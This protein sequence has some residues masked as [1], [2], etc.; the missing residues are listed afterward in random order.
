V[1][2]DWLRLAQPVG[3][4][5]VL[6]ARLVPIDGLTVSIG[7]VLAF[8]PRYREGIQNALQEDRALVERW[9]GRAL[10]WDE[11]NAHYSE[12]LYALALRGVYEAGIDLEDD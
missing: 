10:S 6:F 2:V 12:R 8:P 3:P 1:A 9:N 11:F 4:G 5:D 7:P